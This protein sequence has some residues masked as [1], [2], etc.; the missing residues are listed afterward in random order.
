MAAAAVSL[1][2]NAQD[3]WARIFQGCLDE[4]GGDT[5]LL[6]AF[7]HT[8]RAARY[9]L[10]VHCTRL[11]VFHF[12]ISSASVLD[13]V[14]TRRRNVLIQGPAGCGKSTLTNRLY[15]EASEVIENVYMLAPTQ[16]AAELLTH[17]VTIH[18]FLRIRKTQEMDQL[19]AMY[20]LWTEKRS[21]YSSVFNP[22]DPFPN[23]IIIDEISMTGCNL[24]MNVDFILRRRRNCL[25]RNRVFGGAQ[26]VFVG[27][28]CQ[29]PPVCDTYAFKWGEWP[30]LELLKFTLQHPLRHDC[31]REWFMYLQRVRCGLVRTIGSEEGGPN[32]IDAAEYERI[33]TSGDGRQRPIV[34][35]AE[36]KR[37]DDMNK[38]EFD[39]I[40][41][42]VEKTIFSVDSLMRARRGANG[43]VVWS[44]VQDQHP[45]AEDL[46]K[47]ANTYR[48]PNSI[49]LKVGARYVI[50]YNI[51]KKKGI[52]N[53]ATC[54]YI[55]GDCFELQASGVTIGLS[56]LQ[57]HHVVPTRRQ[58][59]LFI[60]R[61]QIALRLG[62]AQT[63]HKS[64]GATIDRVIA[65]LSTV[66]C[67]G[68]YYTAL[69]RVRSRQDI[70]VINPTSRRLNV[71]GDVLVFVYTP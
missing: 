1:L 9:V 15:K 21:S 37:V 32:I 68:Q 48:L 8:C 70:W 53:G 27:D 64:Q 51:N 65:D 3:M 14:I 47:M 24:L 20:R 61:F 7:S 59:D 60:M 56:E 23:L 6:I 50:T 41:A 40:K 62:Y 54:V 39:R 26:V 30:N 31:D 52:Y 33:M 45:T 25:D 11:S 5:R 63:I 35:G 58:D 28:F 19:E 71:S 69:S 12:V 67:P 44:N 46:A 34:L 4:D 2:D 55:G 42:P 13:A 36:N 66:R 18:S 38:R 10:E 49:Q 22:K 16:A 57:A 29:L 17:G 43:L